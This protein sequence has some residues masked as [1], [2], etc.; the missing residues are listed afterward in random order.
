VELGVELGYSTRTIQ[1][2]LAV[3]ESELGVPLVQLS[4]RYQLMAGSSPLGPV[5]FTL[6]E[7]R[8]LYLATRLFLRHA[9]ERDQDGISALDKLA[10]TL[11]ESIGRQVMTAAAQLRTRP[12]RKNQHDAL[13]RLTEGWAQSRT[14]DI[15]YRSAQDTSLRKTALDPYLLEPSANGAATYVIGF[16]H[17]HNAVRTFKIDRIQ[18]AEVTAATF[19]P[20]DT[21]E[22]VDQLARSWGVVFGDDKYDVVV[23]F[24]PGVTR[25]IRETNWHPSQRLSDLPDGGVR[26]ELQ[27]PSLLELIPWVRGWGPDA[28]VVAP[29]EL[30]A[31]VATSLRAA[32]AAYGPVPGTV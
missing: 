9:D 30:R 17:L 2:D 31:E 32:A 15:R 6:Q 18:H 7:A 13:C 8:A 3:L 12:A 14:V 28:Q 1:R 11:P 19:V 24:R 27:I 26:M 23:D 21:R 5:R 16:S 4:R 25:R 29:A 22:I 10:H 20:P